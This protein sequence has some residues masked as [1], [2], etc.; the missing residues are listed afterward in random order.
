MA[1]KSFSRKYRMFISRLFVAIIVALL[2]FSGS[3]WETRPVMSGIL[4]MIGVMLVGMATVGRLWC[5]LYI[6]GYKSNTL[7]T[8]GPY[9]ISRNPLYFFSFLGAAGVGLTTETI[10]IPIIIIICF[11]I[12]YPLVI[13]SEQKKLV[14]IHKDAFVEYCKSTPV[15][16]P[17]LSLFKEPAEYTVK[18]V[19]FRKAMFEVMWFVWLLG[20]TELAEAL[21]DARVL[22]IL[23]NMY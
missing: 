19:I 16:F 15:F 6:S 1:E 2:I 5:A 23:F 11:A 3:K 4:F 12:L 14:E 21:H 13:L 9:S 22:P 8:I 18:P 20:L 10:L 7:I 17:K